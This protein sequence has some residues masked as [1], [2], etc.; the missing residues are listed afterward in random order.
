[1]KRKSLFKIQFGEALKNHD[2]AKLEKEGSCEMLFM[3]AVPDMDL[4]GS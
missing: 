3:R 1:M 2:N 4:K